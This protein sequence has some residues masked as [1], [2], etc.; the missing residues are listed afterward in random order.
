LLRPDASRGGLG[1][2]AA[3]AQQGAV[4]A[5]A[6]L[7]VTIAM[8]WPLARGLTRD[9]PSDLQ[10]PLFVMWVLSWGAE[11]LR[12]ILGG[13]LARV[14]SFFDA[15]IF[16]PAPLALAYSEH[17]FAQALQILPVYAAT[18]NPILCYNL[19]FLSTF[20]LS[21]LGAFLLVRE[22]TGS[23]R[24]GFVAGLLFA[25]A[26]YR[27]SQLPHLQVMSSQWMPFALYG[28]RRYFATGRRW[29][30]A[31]A[32]TALTL[33]NLSCGY[34]LLYFTP[35]VVSYVLWEIVTRGQWRYAR[36]WVDLTVA[37]LAVIA[38]TLPFLLPYKWLRDSI[39]MSWHIQ[40]VVRY[41]ADVYSYFTAA[42]MNSV[43]GQRLRLYPKPEGHLF[44]GAIPLLLAAT[45]A[46][47]WAVSAARSHPPAAARAP[48]WLLVTIATMGWTYAAV[49]VSAIVMRRFDLDLIV[50]SIRA[51]N[52]TRLLVPPL[53][54]AAA[55]AW[56]SPASRARMI[57][58]ARQPEAIFI[59]ILVLAWWLSL[60][61]SPRV[62]G[63]PL[64][65]WS[66]Y[67]MLIHVVP[68]FDGLRVPARLA[69]IVS[70]ALAILGGIATARLLQGRLGT[71]AIATISLAFLVEADTFPFPLNRVSPPRN[72][73]MPE[74]RVYRPVRAPAIYRELARIPKDAVI[75]EMPI[76]ELDY[77]VRAMYYSTAHWR[78][79]VNGYS[80]FFPPHYDGLLAVLPTALRGDDQAWDALERIGVTHVVVHEGAYLDD[81]GARFADWLRRHGAAEI[82]RD[83]RDA[84]L[85][86]PH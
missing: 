75:L 24:A 46:V 78:R 32:A 41:S 17:L 30:L 67:R 28:F 50:F 65:L 15:N 33:Q 36:R 3:S 13:D 64:E 38:A 73:A 40:E 52:V 12:G 16:Y 37:A 54:A 68:G 51:T 63:R 9:V 83:G 53:I 66:P 82:F 35:V 72:Y 80:G 62:L 86:L 42:D 43:W 47:A 26:P 5:A 57:A 31:G 8:T 14:T 25:F 18:G 23:A 29:A 20:V 56:L 58:A 1:R 61:P 59:A 69:M 48:R 4:V 6:Y 7:V 10:D 19:L 49:A 84:L 77:D 34:Y 11:Q 55:L 39:Q 45:G 70:L 79:L 76:G 21:G 44:P 27:W 74:A 71:I 22:I 2:F 85:A 60:G 81:E